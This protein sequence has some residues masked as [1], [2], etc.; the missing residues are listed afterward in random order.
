MAA[1]EVEPRTGKAAV[2]HT[3]ALPPLEAPEEVEVEVE[4]EGWEAKAAAS[5]MKDLA[6]PIVRP[7]LLRSSCVRSTTTWSVIFSFLRA[8]PLQ[9][10]EGGRRG[11]GVGAVSAINVR[12][13]PPLHP[14]L[15]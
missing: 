1:L 11:V 6:S 5:F 10:E 3:P 9:L 13:R 14:P 4:V 7:R 2:T 12:V 15:T 8:R